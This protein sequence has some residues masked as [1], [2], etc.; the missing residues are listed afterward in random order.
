MIFFHE[1]IKI[2]SVLILLLRRKNIKIEIIPDK[3]HFLKWIDYRANNQWEDYKKNH[4]IATIDQI[5]E[6]LLLTNLETK[7]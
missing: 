7:S 4:K 6:N 3:T 1:K 2:L 5:I